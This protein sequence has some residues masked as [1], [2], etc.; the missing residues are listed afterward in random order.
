L[1]REHGNGYTT[2]KGSMGMAILLKKGAWEWLYMTT[3]GSKELK[4]KKVKR[5][6]KRVCGLMTNDHYIF[7]SS[8][9]PIHQ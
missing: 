3:R 8:H 2:Q 1:E 9:L 6:E 5:C 4:E 7:N